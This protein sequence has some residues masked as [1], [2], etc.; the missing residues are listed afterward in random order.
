[1]KTKRCSWCGDNPLYV[2]YHDTEW[3]IPEYNS[4]ALFGKLILDGAQAGLSWITILR[5]RD[6]YLQAFDGFDP[7]KMA[8][9]SDKKLEALLQ[10]PGIVRNRLKVKSAR[11]NAQ[12]YLRMKHRGVDFSEYLWSFVEGK[13]IQNAFDKMDQM[14]RT[15]PEARAMSKALKNEGFN[16]VGPTIVY[17]FMQAVGMVNDH[18]TSCFRYKEIAS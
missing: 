6:H 13:P 16:F 18:L 11:Q 14:L 7:L 3:G 12:A 17:A 9:Y 1:M 4:K 8:H 5:K 2:K 15:L 10:E